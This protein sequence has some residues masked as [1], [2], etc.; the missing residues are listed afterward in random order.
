MQLSPQLNQL[1]LSD[2]FP[3]MHAVDSTDPS[4]HPRYR[5][6][7]DCDGAQ[8]FIYARSLATVL[9][10]EGEIDGSNANRVATEI[11]RFATMR[12]PLILDLSQL[13]FLGLEGFQQ[14]LALNHEYQT[15]RL[16]CGIVTGVAMRPLLRIVSDHGL[17][18]VKSVPEALQLIND[19]LGT[20]RQFVARIAR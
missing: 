1:L 19:A 12:T 8:I 7:I 9:R 20:R 11:R 18:L 3:L 10:V 4:Q 5:Y 15:S 14:L 16:Y 17:R 6:V 13:Q 2:R